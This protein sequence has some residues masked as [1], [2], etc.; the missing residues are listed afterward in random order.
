MALDRINEEAEDREP[1]PSVQ[2]RWQQ[3][4]FGGEVT[5]AD[6]QALRD[7]LRSLANELDRLPSHRVRR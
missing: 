2:F 5:S 3:T 4:M 6:K 1:R 7:R